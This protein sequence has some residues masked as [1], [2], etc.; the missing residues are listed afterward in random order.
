MREFIPCNPEGQGRVSE[1]MNFIEN[2]RGALREAYGLKGHGKS[3]KKDD[4]D[5]VFSLFP[6][7]RERQKQMGGSL[8]GGE[9][10]ML[11]IGRGLMARPRLLLLD[12]PSLGLAPVI[13]EEIFEL[14]VGINK[15]T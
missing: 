6:R 8:S 5:M 13:I 15:K 10:Q 12:E 14:I 9:Q 2:D 3:T 7:L 11:A 1:A 4:L